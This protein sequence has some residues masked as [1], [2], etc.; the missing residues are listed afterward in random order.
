[1]TPH[2]DEPGSE[3]MTETHED[4]REPLPL[5]DD[6]LAQ[7]RDVNPAGVHFRPDLINR[8]LATIDALKSRL[9]S[10]AIEP[11]REALPALDIIL[12]WYGTLPKRAKERLSIEDLHNLSKAFLSALTASQAQKASNT[13]DLCA[14]L[15]SASPATETVTAEAY[16]IA[17][18]AKAAASGHRHRRTQAIRDTP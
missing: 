5:S 3:H 7:W 1:M 4:A 2:T 18:K 14:A 12:K 15:L 8:F 6:E 16:E 17:A 11:E 9:L 10:P 13:D